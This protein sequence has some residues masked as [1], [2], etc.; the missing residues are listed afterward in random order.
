MPGK[1]RR[2]AKRAKKLKLLLQSLEDLNEDADEENVQ[3]D[4]EEIEE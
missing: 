1:D 4:D 3:V 2:Y